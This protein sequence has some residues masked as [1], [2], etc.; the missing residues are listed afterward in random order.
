MGQRE[1][2]TR[3]QD[4]GKIKVRFKADDG[5]AK[6]LNDT[7]DYFSIFPADSIV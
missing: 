5:D 6:V 7:N 1:T 2:S 3:C 4:E